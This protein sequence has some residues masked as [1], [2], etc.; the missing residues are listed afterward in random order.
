MVKEPV[1]D[2]DIKLRAQSKINMLVIYNYKNL[3]KLKGVYSIILPS[4]TNQLLFILS[5]QMPYYFIPELKN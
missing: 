5:L 1:E 4:L 2:I 3:H